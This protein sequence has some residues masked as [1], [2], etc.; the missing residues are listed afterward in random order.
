MAGGRRLKLNDELEAELIGLIKQ[1]L[2]IG[3][4]ALHAGISRP[5]YYRWRS[6]G[7]KAKSGRYRLF[8]ERV[9]AAQATAEAVLVLRMK[10]HTQINGS[11]GVQATQFLLERR[12]PDRWAKHQVIENR[13]AGHD[14]GP[15]PARIGLDLSSM[16]PAQLAA[17]TGTDLGGDGDELHADEP[18]SEDLDDLPP[19]DPTQDTP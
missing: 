13:A 1:G 5:T 19:L 11:A 15:A 7:Q 4:A 10:A 18:S 9:E 12:F 16:T 6:R 3:V 8:Y 2:P 14:G 17:I